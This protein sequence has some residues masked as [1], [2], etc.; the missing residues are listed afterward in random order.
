MD[1][2]EREPLSSHRP[3]LSI[4]VPTLNN[5]KILPGFLERLSRQ[6]Y[7]GD[8]VE[9]LI[10]DGGSTDRTREIA[11]RHRTRIIDNPHVLAEPGV[12]LGIEN[13][14]GGLI[15][16]LAVDNFLD[17]PAALER[18]VTVF[19]DEA[20]FAAFPKHASD[21]T[22]TLYT[23]YINTF[24]DPFNH[25]I[26]GE[27]ANARTFGHVYRVV[28]HNDL[29]DVYDF[30]SSPRRPLIALAQGLTLRSGFRRRQED[31]FDDCLPILDLI[32]SGRKI[33]YVH[34]VSLYHHT[35]SSWRHFNLKQ[36]WAVRNALDKKD[37]GI[38]YRYRQLSRDQRW[39]A[40][41]WPLYAFSVVLPSGRALFGAVRDREPIWLFHPVICL[42]SAGVTAC[43]VIGY[44][45]G[46]ERAVSRQL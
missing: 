46:K 6:T 28:E 44:Y 4:V 1:G 41:L 36:R 43:E 13:A 19:E 20:V 7:T 31:R 24:T 22:D 5:E 23:R 30:S 3:T 14:R 25:F 37:Y 26:Y 35:V 11:T 39:R 32:T 16:V 40:R 17:D 12:D 33:A 18:M 15:M 34:S 10:V 45:L 27:A 38:A 29:F 21:G 8:D 2:L 9:I 42:Q